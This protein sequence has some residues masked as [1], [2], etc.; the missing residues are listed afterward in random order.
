M[1]RAG[2]FTR[3]RVMMQASTARILEIGDYRYFKQE[4]PD[5]TTLLWTARIPPGKLSSSEYFDC[6]PGNYLRAM[7]DARAGRYDLIVAYIS[8]RSPWSPLNWGRSLGHEPWR[9]ITATT[10]VFGV[11]WL[12]LTPLPVPLVVID[13]SDAFVIRRHNFFLLDK[14]KIV[15]KR[16]LPADRWH[17]LCGSAH[18]L[19]PSRRMRRKARWQKRLEK[20]RPLV[21]PGAPIDVDGLWDGDFPEK[22]A[23]IFF[24]GN[25]AEN[26]WVR[27]TGM[28]E[29]QSL[30]S[31]G[32]RVDVP[33]APLP[34]RD[35]Q[36]RLARAWLSWSPSGYGWECMRTAE[37]AQCLSVPV[38]N[39]PTIERY[40]PLLN[41]EHAIYYDIEPGGL[42]RAVAAALADKERLRRM[43]CAARD[44]VLTY[45]T[46]RAVVD[47]V[48]ESALTFRMDGRHATAN[49][50]E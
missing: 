15:F 17:V 43:A 37:A 6:S 24:S 26:S 1:V 30:A 12:K 22:S 34:L 3:Q 10:R 2:P 9:P 13:M 7:A 18:P 21:L 28:A 46:P 8:G 32:I 41:G 20:L 36:R 11:S 19:L 48:I 5:R 39:N 42:T 50:E 31:R 47:Y 27:R 35:F 40:R 45:H 44:H 38:L 29:L 49:A 23:D 33:S 25:V 14:A 4:Y 16:E